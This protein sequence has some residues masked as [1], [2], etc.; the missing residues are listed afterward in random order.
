MTYGVEG[1]AFLM[2]SLNCIKLSV[3][4]NRLSNAHVRHRGVVSGRGNASIGKCVA[5]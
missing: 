1:D 2:Y 4:T 5:S 3:A